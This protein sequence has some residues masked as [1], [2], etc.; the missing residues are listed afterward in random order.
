MFENQIFDVSYVH[1]IKATWNRVIIINRHIAKAITHPQKTKQ[2]YKTGSLLIQHENM[3]VERTRLSQTS[4]HYKTHY[5]I[6]Q[7]P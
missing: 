6:R 4:S 7:Q 5:K 3:G 2:R 1:V